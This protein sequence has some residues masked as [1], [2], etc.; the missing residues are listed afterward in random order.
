MELPYKG[1]FQQ[2]RGG[3]LRRSTRQLRVWGQALRSLG[4]PR[5]ATTRSIRHTNSLEAS[6]PDPGRK[7]VAGFAMAT[8]YRDKK[9]Q[10][11]RSTV[12][13]RQGQAAVIKRRQPCTHSTGREFFPWFSHSPSDGVRRASRW[14]ATKEGC[15]GHRGSGARGA[16]AMMEPSFRGLQDPREEGPTVARG[17][18]PYEYSYPTG[19]LRPLLL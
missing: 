4:T 19:I 11:R 14:G 16:A 10:M 17:G 1:R 7:T 18:I 5:R 15:R 8:S 13:R 9:E 3:R 2:L 12:P 6:Q